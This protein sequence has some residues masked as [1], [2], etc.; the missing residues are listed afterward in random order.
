VMML[1]QLQFF[2]RFSAQWT[3]N[4]KNLFAKCEYMIPWGLGLRR[5]T[6]SHITS[7]ARGHRNRCSTRK[8][9]TM[10][11]PEK[12]VMSPHDISFY[13]SLVHNQHFYS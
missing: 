4:K 5:A 2:Q 6:T 10:A 11:K 8:P 9:A 1:K 7:A 12:S 3:S 13:P